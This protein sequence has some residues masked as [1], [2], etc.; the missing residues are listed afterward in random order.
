M[1]DSNAPTFSTREEIFPWEKDLH[2]DRLAEVYAE[3]NG[4]D[5]EKN[6]DRIRRSM[7]DVALELFGDGQTGRRAI[8]CRSIDHADE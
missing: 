7:L 4:W 8:E 2:L 3:I 1:T 5:L 6:R